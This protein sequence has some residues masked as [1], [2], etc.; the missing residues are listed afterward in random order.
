MSTMRTT[1]I[2]SSVVTRCPSLNSTGMLNLFMAS[3]MARPPPWMMTG[4]TPMIFKSTMSFMTSVRNRPSIIADP[5]YLMT[6]VFPVMFL[7]QG[8]ASTRT[9]AVLLDTG[10]GRVSFAYFMFGNLH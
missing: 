6:T 2:A 4:L 8:S 9:S 5:P 7:I 1:S 10:L 3:V